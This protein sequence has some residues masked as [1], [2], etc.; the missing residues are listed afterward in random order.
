MSIFVAWMP[1]EDAQAALCSLQDTATANTAVAPALRRKPPQLHMTLRYLGHG[2]TGEQLQL[3][4]AALGQVATDTPRLMLQIDRLEYWPSAGVLVAC[5]QPS[6][7]MATLI[8]A[9]DAAAGQ[10][11]FAPSVRAQTPHITLAY[12]DRAVAPRVA[13][14]P[15]H[16][17]PLALDHISLVESAQ[18][19]YT[20]R[21]SW[22]LQEVSSPAP[23]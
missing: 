13:P 9:A 1:D 14:L 23:N 21:G 11:G 2:A 4:V 5:P 17:P 15:V 10:A 22:R 12:L 6:P 3:L 20:T 7:R 18:H 19:A 16:G 8:A